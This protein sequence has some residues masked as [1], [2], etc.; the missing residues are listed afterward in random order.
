MNT[1]Q[2]TPRTLTKANSKHQCLNYNFSF[3]PKTLPNP[4]R[5]MNA[6]RPLKFTALAFPLC[7]KA[8]IR[9]HVL[10]SLILLNLNMN[11]QDHIQPQ[12]KF[13]HIQYVNAA[14][15][16]KTRSYNYLL[17][18]LH[19]GIPDPSYEPAHKNQEPCVLR[20]A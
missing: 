9:V 10:A 4:V 17:L 18:Q 12:H 6:G 3:I 2:I 19:A 8:T 1:N 15:K 5:K 20:S 11:V 16:I 14:C 7:C 13:W